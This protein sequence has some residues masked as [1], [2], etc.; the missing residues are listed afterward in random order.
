M[1]NKRKLSP[2]LY[3][4]T[5]FETYHVEPIPTKERQGT[6]EVLTNVVYSIC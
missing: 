6:S 1:Y 5:Y 4:C 3:H 2:I